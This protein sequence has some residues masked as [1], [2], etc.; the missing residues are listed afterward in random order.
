VR[1]KA[2]REKVALFMTYIIIGSLFCFWL[3]FITALFCD[4]PATY[5]YT[6]VYANNSKLSSINGKVVDWHELGNMS[7]MTQQVNMYP[8]YDLS[9][10]FPKFMMLQRPANQ[11]NYNN[12]IIDSCINGFNRSTE[13]DNWL[14]YKLTH[15]PGYVFEN[16][17]L[18]S[19]PMPNKRNQTGMP[20]FYSLIA[21]LEYNRYPKKGGI[22]CICYKKLFTAVSLISVYNSAKIQRRFCSFELFNITPL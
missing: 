9:P 13:A 22:Y 1:R 17:R 4:T 16:N 10:M 19:C 18:I 3:E 8:H 2:W 21:E 14:N 6:E 12:R 11:Y 5:D 7:D 20:C 15:D